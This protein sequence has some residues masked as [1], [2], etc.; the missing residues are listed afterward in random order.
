MLE[1]SNDLYLP[2]TN[3]TI[4]KEHIL[5]HPLIIDTKDCLESE[6]K[7]VGSISP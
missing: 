4:Q 1:G 7:G 2:L 6:C 3:G 5:L